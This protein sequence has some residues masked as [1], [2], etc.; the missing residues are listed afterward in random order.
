MR[1]VFW[2]AA[3]T[4]IS[5][6]PLHAQDTARALNEV[7]ITATRFPLKQEATGKVVT[8]IN[9]QDIERSAGRDLAQLLTAQAGI[10]VNGAWS[11]P[12]KDKSVF[13]RGA[14]SQY[15]LILL[16]GIPL[17]DPSGIGGTF[18]IRLLPLENI[19][20][21][22]VLKGA[23]STLYGSNAIAGVINIISRKPSGD[24]RSATGLLSY[25]SYNTLRGNATL[26]RQ[27]GAFDYS[28]AY[29]YF[30]TEGI[31]EAR[32]RAGAD[33]FDRDGFQRQSFNAVVGY[34]PA[35]S[36]RI[37]PFFRV[38]D[39]GGGYDADA[40]TDGPQRYKAS[41][42]ASG[43][44]ATAGYGAGNVS[45][46]YGYDRTRRDFNGYFLGGS[47][48]HADGFVNHRFSPGLQLLAG[49]AYQSYKLPEPD[50][51]NTILSPY[52]SLYMKRA[53]FHLEVGG[54]YNRHS[55]FGSAFTYSINP[56]YL[57]GERLKLFANW[58]TGFRAPSI[59][60][61]FG[62]FGA[63]PDLE[64]ETGRT[65]E[66]GLQVWALD[67]SLSLVATYF[68]RDLKDAITYAFPDGYI[69]RD[70]Q[71]DHGVEAELQFRPSD[72]WTLRANYTYVDGEITQDLGGK[73][74]SFYNLLR[75]P[76][77]SINLYAGAQ[78]LPK[79]FLS[80]EVQSAAARQDVFFDPAQFYAAVP[81]TLAPYTLIHASAEWGRPGGSFRLFADLR[82]IGDRN[83]YYE[84]YGYNAQGFNGTAGV[85][86]RL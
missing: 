58:S 43:L 32:Q 49:M 37:A 23:Q 19:E 65:L 76:R 16:D 40:F 51:T 81:Q 6:A 86:L 39:Y 84:V 9:R 72:R 29:D 71:E 66:G 85:R 8:V 28:L 80:L 64:P 61:L 22:E 24:A 4:I 56:S 59:S 47:F 1:K 53:G 34:R 55:R 57:F 3:V 31:S 38:S 25:G 41:L 5:A 74:T 77:H 69:N 17:N 36:V 44:K 14:A 54:R 27:S 15:T 13:L 42:I 30:D 82:N 33:S 50:T 7:V 45:L 83:E 75:R 48:H 78:A 63:N 21:I 70:R 18:D 2:A 26:T 12:G 35:S 11:N 52:A 62:P 10:T 79:L 68:N 60:E 73:D 20:R 46:D 67:R